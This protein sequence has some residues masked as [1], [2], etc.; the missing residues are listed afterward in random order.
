MGARLHVQ[1]HVHLARWPGDH[2]VVL[3]VVSLSPNAGSMSLAPGPSTGRALCQ[4]ALHGEHM[5]CMS[6]ERQHIRIANIG[7]ARPKA[8]FAQVLAPCFFAVWP[9][10]NVQLF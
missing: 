2:A 8:P 7:R 9:V 1:V 5:L 6:V 4:T 3:C 10:V